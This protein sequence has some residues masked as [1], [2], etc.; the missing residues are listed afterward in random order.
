MKVQLKSYNKYGNNKT[1]VDGIRFD[2]KAESERYKQLKLLEYAG[3]ITD[4]KLQ[5]KYLLSPK[6]TLEAKCE[7]RAD[8]EYKENG[9]KVVE[10]VKGKL[11]KEYIVKRKWFRQKYPDI[12]FRE[13]RT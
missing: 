1:V 2:S 5:P 6:T 11:T 10:D 12:E 3:A 13:F 7:Y 9:H 8:F 4:L